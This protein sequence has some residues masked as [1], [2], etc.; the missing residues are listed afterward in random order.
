[1]YTSQKTNLGSRH[2]DADVHILPVDDLFGRIID[3]CRVEGGN[4]LEIKLENEEYLKLQ[5]LKRWRRVCVSSPALTAGW[6]DRACAAAFTNADMKPSL[7][8]CFFRKASLWTALISWML[9]EENTRKPAQWTFSLFVL[10]F[11]ILAELRPLTSCP[12][13]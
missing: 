13:R 7:M 2:G 1:M 8:L 5:W 9:L 4:S 10:R 12:P 3:D 6:S 11:I